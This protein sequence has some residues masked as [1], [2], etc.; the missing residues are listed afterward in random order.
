[1]PESAKNLKGEPD[2]V[3]YPH[4]RDNVISADADSAKSAP[5]VAPDVSMPSLMHRRRAM[6]KSITYVGFDLHKD[7]IAIALALA[8]AG[9]RG[10]VR[11]HGKILNTPPP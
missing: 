7:T 4:M 2:H 9:K 8:E 6:D 5:G 3:K 11:E 10:D 1:M